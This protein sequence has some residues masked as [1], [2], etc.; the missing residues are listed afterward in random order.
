MNH[1]NHIVLINL[2]KMI[3]LFVIV[4]TSHKAN[5]KMFLNRL[6]LPCVFQCVK[7]DVIVNF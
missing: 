5:S 2:I 1:W 3:F 7:K 4:I 6:T